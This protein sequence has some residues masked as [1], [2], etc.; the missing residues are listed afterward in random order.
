MNWEIN[1]EGANKSADGEW[2]TEWECAGDVCDIGDI[3]DTGDTG[4]GRW[5]QNTPN[6]KWAQKQGNVERNLAHKLW[7]QEEGCRGRPSMVLPG[8]GQTVEQW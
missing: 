6:T 2:E 5:A 4:D 8:M 7:T 3:G 1:R